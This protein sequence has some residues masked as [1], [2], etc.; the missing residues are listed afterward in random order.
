MFKA[1]EKTGDKEINY[2]IG[3]FFFYGTFL[4]GLGIVPLIFPQNSLALQWT[5]PISSIFWYIGYAF[6][7]YFAASY[8]LSLLQ[9]PLMVLTLIAG[10]AVTVLIFLNPSDTVI[11]NGIILWNFQ[12]PSNILIPLFMTTFIALPM[13]AFFY[14]TFKNADQVIRRRSLLLGLSLLISIIGGPTHALVKTS[15]QYLLVDIIL[16]GS[17]FLRLA[18]AIYKR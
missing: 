12:V 1:K 13:S 3:H 6:L 7:I 15:F 16:V 5:F 14:E 2:F 8:R 18:G 4:F 17:Y 11:K 9:K 10:V